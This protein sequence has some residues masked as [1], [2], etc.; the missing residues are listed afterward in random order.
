MSFYSALSEFADL[1]EYYVICHMFERFWET[2]NTF[3]IV[4]GDMTITPFD[5]SMLIDLRITG[6]PSVYQVDFYTSCDKL[7]DPFGPVIESISNRD[8]FS[9]NILIDL[10]H[11]NEKWIDIR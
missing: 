9:Y 2:T 1:T 5:F 3:H 8:D 7:F 4:F 11:N 10:M 6:K